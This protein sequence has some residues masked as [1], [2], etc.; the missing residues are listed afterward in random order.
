MRQLIIQLNEPSYDV[1][2]PYVKMNKNW[3]TQKGPDQSVET[4]GIGV[5]APNQFKGFIKGDKAKGLQWL[6]DKTNRAQITSKVN[7]SKED[8]YITAVLQDLKV[9][10]EPVIEGRNVQFDIT[11][12]TTVSLNSY[13]ESVT[14]NDIRETVERTV[15]KDIETTFKEGLERDADIFRLSEVLYRNNNKVWGKLHT[16]GKVPLTEN[17]I[18]K[19]NIIVDNIDSGRK[20]FKTT[21]EKN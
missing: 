19:I 11:L 12:N 6:S 8:D 2:I 14:T 20:S 21:I 10:I 16:D 7:S 4:D 3:K 17:S 18:R 5:I 15:K 1:K 13:S 9:R